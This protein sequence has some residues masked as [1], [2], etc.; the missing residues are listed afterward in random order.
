MKASKFIVLVGGILGIV[1]F[2]LPLVSV[3]RNGKS[4]SVSAFQVVKGLDAVQNELEK[5]NVRVSAA[6]YGGTAAL[7]EA[8]DGLEN[9]KGIV[10]GMFAPALLLAAI[11]GAGVGRK[12]FGRV[13]G[14]FT[15]LFGL[16]ALGIGALAKSAAGAESGIGI[17]LMLLAGV[18]GVVGGLITLVKP[19]RGEGAMHPAVSRAAA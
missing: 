6:A 7:N 10:L 4:A 15:L 11:G 16:L 12:K 5:D 18:A 17:T 1:A 19:D 3:E 14:S 2:F 8:N 9:A 13:A